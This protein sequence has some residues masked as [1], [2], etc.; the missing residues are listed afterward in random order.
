MLRKYNQALMNQMA[1][2]VACNR[3]HN[4]EERMAR[5]LLMTHDRVEAD[6]FLLT[7]E[8][9]AQMLG[10]RRPTVTV[11]AGV[12]ERAGLIAVGRGRVM[13]LNRERLEAASCECYRVVREEFD[14]L[15]GPEGQ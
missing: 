7:Q 14:R 15:L 5:W 3:L 13:V 9:L 2:S 6:Q 10:V 11:T 4:V 8:F 1:Q 12:L